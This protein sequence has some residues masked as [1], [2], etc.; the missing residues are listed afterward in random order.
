MHEE[1]I[2]RRFLYTFMM[3]LVL[4][5]CRGRLAENEVVAKVENA[6]LS[7]EEMKQKMAWEG[8]KPFQESDFIKRWVDQE[9]LYQEAK[10]LGL[11]NSVKLRWELEQVEKEYLIQEL[12]EGTF[13]DRVH[14][15]EEEIASYYEENKE[16]FLVEEDEVRAQHIL[17]RTKAEADIARQEIIA[18]KP[19]DEVAKEHSIGIFR[20]KGGNMGFIKK[21]DVIREIERYA[22]R[23][24]EGGISVVFRSNHGYHIVKVLKKRTTGDLKDLADVRDDIFQQLCVNRER[25][26]YYELLSQLQKKTEVYVAVPKNA[27]ELVD[28]LTVPNQQQGLEEIEK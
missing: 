25:S 20:D 3:V 17:T 16:A 13:A 1:W 7:R 26:V 8:L 21:Q 22:F 27:N 4:A 19:F 28:T 6:V 2:K 5:G 23:L 12:L 9:L 15:T 18:G 10:R 24:P 14:V 11:D